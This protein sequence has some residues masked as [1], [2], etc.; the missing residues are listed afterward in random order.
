MAVNKRIVSMSGCRSSP[1]APLCGASLRIFGQ[2]PPGLMLLVKGVDQVDHLSGFAKARENLLL[3]VAL[4]IVLDEIVDDLRSL[5]DDGGIETF[6]GCEFPHRRLINQQDAVEHP[7]F[8]HQIFRRR[9]FRHF[10]MVSVLPLTLCTVL[11]RAGGR[12]P[13]VARLRGNK[14]SGHAN[15]ASPAELLFHECYSRGAAKCCAARRGAG[16]RSAPRRLVLSF[17]IL[18]RFFQSA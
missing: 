3:F 8:A 11:L 5:T 12:G 6:I 10:V 1:G 14:R 18:E 16:R 7:V 4:V 17:V 15:D 2:P 13:E 9:N